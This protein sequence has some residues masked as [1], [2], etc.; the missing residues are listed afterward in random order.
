MLSG[1]GN[2]FSSPL[3]SATQKIAELLG[4][5]NPANFTRAF[6][7]WTGRTPSQFRVLR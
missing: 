6:K 2:Y 7:E 4:Y 1:G 3:F 5:N